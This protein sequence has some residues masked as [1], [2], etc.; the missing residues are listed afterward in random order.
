[1]VASELA[2]VTMKG[3]VDVDDDPEP[4]PEALR[5][6]PGS[7]RGPGDS[8]G[9]RGFGH[10]Q[11]ADGFTYGA[12]SGQRYILRAASAPRPDAED[13]AAAG[14]QC[15]DGV[16]SLRMRPAA[17]IHPVVSKVD[18]DG[19]GDAEGGRRGP[20]SVGTASVTGIRREAQLT[21][22]SGDSA[23]KRHP[24]AAS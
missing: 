24:T 11:R 14:R 6:G 20:P 23:G 17:R 9:R 21:A 22:I 13:R 10:G 2:G 18:P 7:L 15:P 12:F 8:A 16:S 5:A 4:E 1:V 3:D 19:C